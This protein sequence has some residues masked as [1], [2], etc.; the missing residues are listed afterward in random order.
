VV[1]GIFGRSDLIEDPSPE[2]AQADGRRFELRLPFGCAGPAGEDSAEP[3][4]WRYDPKSKALRIHV[5]PI[6]WTARD[7]SPPEV[8]DGVEGIEGFWVERPWT[9]SEACPSGED[10]AAAAVADP[11][12]V[13]GRTLALG[14]VS[15]AEGDRG[16]RR[17]G[18][19]FEAVVRVEESALRTAQG[20]RLRI[21]G[22]IARTGAFGPV[23]CR[24]PGPGQ[25]PVCL[26][27]VVMDEVAVENPEG[28]ETLATWSLGGRNPPEG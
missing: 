24:L 26:V 2:I 13:A 4:R 23:R 1:S 20:F 22:R 9:S 6:D 5:D 18:K 27:T 14:Q 21:S 8:A 17:G 10:G 3:M 25:R 12:A 7:W 28:N 15:L 19:P 16:G 11:A